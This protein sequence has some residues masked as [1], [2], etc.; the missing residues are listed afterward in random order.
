LVFG[1]DTGLDGIEEVLERY[2]DMLAACDVPPQAQK[3][4]LGGTMA[5]T[6]GLP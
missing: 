2:R 5:K 3:L 1:S 6:L 4:I